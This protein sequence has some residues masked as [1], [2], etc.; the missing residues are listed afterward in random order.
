MPDP[1]RTTSINRIDASSGAVLFDAARM[2]FGDTFPAAP[3][4]GWCHFKTTATVGWY[5]WDGSN[6]YLFATG[7]TSAALPSS[8]NY[9]RYNGTVWTPVTIAQILTD[10]LGVDG[11]GSL[12]D[13]DLLDGVQGVGYLRADADDTQEQ[14]LTVTR[15]RHIKSST[16]GIVEWGTSSF[17]QFVYASGSGTIAITETGGYPVGQTVYVVVSNTS[18]VARALTFPAWSWASNTPPQIE[19]GDFHLYRLLIVDATVGGVIAEWVQDPSQIATSLTNLIPIGNLSNVTLTAPGAVHLLVYDGVG[20]WLNIDGYALFFGSSAPLHNIAD[21]G[22]APA[23]NDFLRR[24][25]AGTSWE[26]VDLAEI[27]P[28]FQGA[29]SAG[30]TTASTSTYVPVPLGAE[31]FKHTGYT[32]STSTNPSEVTIDNAGDYEIS[33]K[34]QVIE[35][36]A[37]TRDNLRARIE[38]DVG[39]G[40]GA[41]ARCDFSTYMRDS[42]SRYTAS[43]PPMRVTLGAGDKLRMVFAVA[44]GTM[45]VSTASG[46][47]WLRIRKVS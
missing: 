28:E 1:R 10:L 24:N 32:H 20:T 8:G 29:D 12:L 16:A 26:P 40:F 37:G 30:G 2:S 39:A 43:L 9:L 35:T 27:F 31:D 7:G 47:S 4:A 41:L 44:G 45:T 17:F 19:S 25:A 5:F 14:A 22:A 42:V 3:H 36:A 6:W 38:I 18:G 33:A 34:L 11:A 13:A 21:V 46:Q 23:A 15:L